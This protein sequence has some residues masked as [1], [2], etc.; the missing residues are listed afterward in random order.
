[1][2]I[3]LAQSTLRVNDVNDFKMKDAALYLRVYAFLIDYLIIYF[4]FY[5]LIIS[6]IVFAAI[7]TKDTAYTILILFM[8]IIIYI[9]IF[10]I[11]HFSGGSIGKQILGLKV[12]SNENRN[13]RIH[14]RFI[15]SIGY[16]L[17][18]FL[19]CCS[20]IRSIIFCERDPEIYSYRLIDIMIDYGGLFDIAL[21]YI[22]I[23]LII[24]FCFVFI[25]DDKKMLH[26]YYTGSHVVNFYNYKIKLY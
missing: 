25:S 20:L 24:D 14:N 15:R 16:F 11:S 21:K 13:L 26:D 22:S 19:F 23:Y 18:F 17:Y 2:D 12:L 6:P 7:R 1:M 9:L 10:V 8:L 5:K 4:I 3:I